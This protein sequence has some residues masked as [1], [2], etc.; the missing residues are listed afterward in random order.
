MIGKWIGPAAA[1]L[2]AAGILT[3][4]GVGSQPLE[5]TVTVADLEESAESSPETADLSE[6]ISVEET[7]QGIVLKAGSKPLTAE[8]EATLQ[9]I[10][11]QLAND[12]EHSK[13][14]LDEEFSG[15][16][17]PQVLLD[18][19]TVSV[20]YTGTFSN[21]KGD[22]LPVIATSNFQL[23]T[24]SRCNTRIRENAQAVAEAI[25]RGDLT[26]L[27]SDADR[28]DAQRKDLTKQGTEKLVELLQRCDYSDYHSIAPCFSYILEENESVGLYLPVAEDA[29]SWALLLVPQ[30]LLTA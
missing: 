29:G 22:L 28:Q 2:L 14:V 9:A 10:N 4:C 25:V 19:D 8:E 18:K 16:L 30:S 20:V 13:T 5:S 24:G 6:S 21:G 3:G 7:E 15:D 26:I 17:A 1:A 27:E 23:S 11:E 12:W